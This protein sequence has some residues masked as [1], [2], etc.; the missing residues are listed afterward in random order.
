MAIMFSNIVAVMDHVFMN[1]SNARYYIWIGSL[2]FGSA[3]L[4][5]L[6]I[7]GGVKQVVPLEGV[8]LR[9]AYI[10][11]YVVI[12]F[13]GLRFY[14]PR[15]RNVWLGGMMDE[16]YISLR[17]SWIGMVIGAITGTMIFMPQVKKIEFLEGSPYLLV[18]AV[19]FLV[20]MLILVFLSF[21]AGRSRRR[22]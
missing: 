22:R 4:Y 15:L 17:G 12:S 11:I 10:A 13:F 18:A 5:T 16:K 14:I 8:Y 19:V 3:G 21:Y 20:F 9:G 1:F 7:V 2:I 6:I